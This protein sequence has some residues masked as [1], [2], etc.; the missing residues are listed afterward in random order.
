MKYGEWK[1]VQSGNLAAIK[2]NG[3]Q[4]LWIKFNSNKIYKYVGFSKDDYYKFFMADSK[5]K[6]FHSKIKNNKNIKVTQ[7]K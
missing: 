5:G 6:F 7:E 3:K 2:H 4:T 1:E